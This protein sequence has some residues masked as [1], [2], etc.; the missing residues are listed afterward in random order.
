MNATDL[1]GVKYQLTALAAMVAVA[2]TA[3]Y[4]TDNAWDAAKRGFQQQEKAL[5]EARTRL[6]RS[7]DEKQLIVR[8]VDDYRNLERVGF[9]G[10]E[11]RINWLDGLRL[12]NQQTQLF[13]VDY[14]IGA[15]R[16]YPFAAELD[17]GQLA[18]RESVMKLNFK[19]LHEGDLM[20]FFQTLAK[21]SVGVFS[22]NEC[23]LNRLTTT[24]G[25]LRN[26]P[27]IGAECEIAWITI[28]PAT[29]G[30]K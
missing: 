22:I 13:G 6:Q 12:T 17:P 14:Q 2:A 11:Q 16:P 28:T 19:L 29:G 15:Q 7:G 24:A 30:Q 5:Q 10:E 20:R 25:A 26:Q 21:Q 3:V 9:V 27:N 1:L 18:L 23:T 4:Y 8:Y